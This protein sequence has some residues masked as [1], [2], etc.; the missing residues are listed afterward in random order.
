MMDKKA[1]KSIL[2][3]RE[4]EVVRLVSLGYTNIQIGE[5]L[6]I[7][8]RTVERHKANMMQKLHLKEQHELVQFA[9]KNKYVDLI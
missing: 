1:A 9:L 3:Q 6:N 2:T 4:Q 5:H 8:P 7:S